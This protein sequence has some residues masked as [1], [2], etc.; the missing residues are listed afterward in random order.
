MP[1]LKNNS[2]VKD[3][4]GGDIATPF[5][6][7]LHSDV[8]LVMYYAPWDFDSQLAIQDFEKIANKY[9]GQV[10]LSYVLL[11]YLQECDYY[12]FKIRSYAPQLIVGFKME[13]V[14]KHSLN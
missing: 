14:K 5:S 11:L 2:S 4:Y 12:L 7:V 6:E 8:S 9:R 3:Y 13:L 1:F 10:T